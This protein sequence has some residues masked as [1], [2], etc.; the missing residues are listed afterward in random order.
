[1]D[2]VLRLKVSTRL[3]VEPVQGTHNKVV[4]GFLVDF[5]LPISFHLI[6]DV[7]I[8]G[9]AARRFR[10]QPIVGAFGSSRCC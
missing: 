10:D 2:T 6:E 4:V 8:T 1:M 3:P 9:A 5:D 7:E